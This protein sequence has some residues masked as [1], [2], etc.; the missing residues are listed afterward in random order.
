MNP[1]T[2][3]TTSTMGIVNDGRRYELAWQIMIHFYIRIVKRA[4]HVEFPCLRSIQLYR[5]RY[6]RACMN[7]SKYNAVIMFAINPLKRAYIKLTRYSMGGR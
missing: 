2:T 4:F 1:T 3:T 5:D 6:A 7:M